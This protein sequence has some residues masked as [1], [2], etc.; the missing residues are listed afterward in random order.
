MRW[1]SKT[2]SSSYVCLC[3]IVFDCLPCLLEAE[4]ANLGSFTDVLMNLKK[5]MLPAHQ[6]CFYHTLHHEAQKVRQFAA[7]KKP[8][9]GRLVADSSWLW[10][11]LGFL[12]FVDFPYRDFPRAFAMA[13][14]FF[15]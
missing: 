2:A 7:A 12:E 6:V 1:T 5:L 4:Q 10:E 13:C 14:L 9:T 11:L 15:L 3:L 8:D